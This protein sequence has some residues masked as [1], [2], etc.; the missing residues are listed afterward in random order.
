MLEGKSLSQIDNSLFKEGLKVKFALQKF[1][2]A[3]GLPD[4]LF[5]TLFPVFKEFFFWLLPCYLEW[6]I[7]FPIMCDPNQE[8]GN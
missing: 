4:S 8:P 1:S 6:K 5:F 2:M 3:T 7:T